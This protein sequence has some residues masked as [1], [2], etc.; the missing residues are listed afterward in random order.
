MRVTDHAVLRYLERVEGFDV[1][2]LREQLA[3]TEVLKLAAALGNGEYPVGK[4]GEGVLV[5]NEGVV[6][7]V[8]PSRTKKRMLDKRP[9]SEFSGGVDYEQRVKRERA[10][11][12]KRKHI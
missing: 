3:N 1:E 10:S 12:R 8:L 6:V 2:D 9:L 11:K 7:T 4:Q 5:V